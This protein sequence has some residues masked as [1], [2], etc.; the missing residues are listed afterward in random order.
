MVHDFDREVI[1]I[2]ERF[3]PMVTVRRRGGDAAWFDGDCRRAFELKQSAYHRW[4]R[5]RSAVNWGLFC[6]ARGT[7]NRLYAAVRRLVTLRT[8]VGIL[9]TVPLRMTWWR[10]LKGHV[11]GAESDI[12]P[13]CSPGGALVSDPAGK[14]ELLSTWFDSKQSRDIV[15]LPQTFYPLYCIL[16]HC[17]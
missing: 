8:A 7:A 17:L 3:I 5:N 2:M 16:W 15:E 1:G 10:T 12:P 6:Q 4:C 11:F 9:M 14:A 13:L